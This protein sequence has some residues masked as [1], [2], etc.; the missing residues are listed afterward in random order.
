MAQMALSD[1]QN[2]IVRV[3]RQSLIKT[4][5][6]NLKKHVADYEEAVAGYR[7]MGIAKLKE[8][9][10]ETVSKLEENYKKVSEVINA[11]DPKDPN[12]SASD[13]IVLLDRVSVRLRVPRSYAK[14]YEMAIDMATWDTRD[15]LELSGAEFQCF[16]R[17]QWDWSHD[18]T[19]VSSMYKLKKS[20]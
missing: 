15:E 4:L 12:F 5:Q 1:Q 6:E 19:T 17:D 9:H 7:D 8:R 16:I 14:D 3:N 20:F 2:R 10:A 13:D 11:F 18:F